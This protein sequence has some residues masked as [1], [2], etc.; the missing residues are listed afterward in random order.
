MFI[1]DKMDGAGGWAGISAKLIFEVV[2]NDPYTTDRKRY[3]S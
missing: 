2:I 3:D 1:K